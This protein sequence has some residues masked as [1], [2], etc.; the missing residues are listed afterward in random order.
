M[1]L[2][3]FVKELFSKAQEEGFSEY[4]V[5]YVD[6]ESLS[7]SVYKEE[8]EKYN[9]NNSAGLSF[10]GKFGDRIGYSYTEIL[11]EDAIEML[12]K[13]AKENVLAIENNDI[14]FIYEGDKEYKEISTYHEELEDIPADKLINIAISM[15]KEAKKYCNKVESFSG[16][17]VLYSSG[18]YGIINSKGLNL[19]NKSN[20]LTAYVVPIVKDLDKMYDGCGYVVAKSLNDVKPDKIAKM[21]V[22][23]ALSKIGGTSIASGNY[24]V[25]IN[26]EAMVSLLSTFAGIF[27][28]DAVQKGL[29]LLKDK[30]GEIIATDIVNLVDDPHLEDGLASVSFDDEGV[31]TL[32]TYLIKNGKLNSLLHNL[33]TANKAGVKSTGNGFKAS[34]ASPI[35]VSPTNF[36]IEPGIN[37]LEEMTKKIN[38]GLIIT[39]FA[40][41]HSGAN[42]ITGDF[43]LAAKG[44]YIE[45]GIK[46]HPVEQI[47]VAGNFFTL[48]NNIEEIGSDLKFPMSSVGSPSII[49]KELS[50]A[51]EGAKNE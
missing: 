41:L 31:A 11:D 3:L 9:L 30:E 5:Y 16:C 26:N 33:K 15:E 40:G 23:E 14:Q 47:T 45:D 4:E 25:I 49:I 42:S 28:G 6:R 27:S 34:Y 29:S 44:F 20:L 19:S 48:L 8:V 21:G 50:I 17:S 1:E 39:D 36:Y 22:D 35:S 24:K 13:K 7:I 18:K 46:T 43:S 12:V 32:K 38:K 51:G 2:N 37:S 10:R